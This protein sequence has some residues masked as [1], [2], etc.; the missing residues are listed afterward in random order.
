[1]RLP[2]FLEFLRPRFQ[3][4]DDQYGL[5]GHVLIESH[6]DGRFS[7][8]VYDSK[9]FIVDGGI[10]GLRNMILGSTT[11]G[12]DRTPGSSPTPLSVFRM[13][14]G[15]GGTPAGQLFSPR[16]PDAT[17][18]ARTGLFYEVLRQDISVFSAPSTV[19]ARFVSAF[20]S[21]DVDA[22]SFSLSNKVI[23][24]ASLIGGDGTLTIGGD[25]KQINKSPPD[26][27]DADEFLVSMRTFNSTP[28]NPAEDI[29]LTVTWTLSLIVSGQPF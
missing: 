14:I 23:N 16:Q 7:H 11:G 21:Q 18:P 12:G 1:M 24:E 2:P 8:V 28:F 27:A 4:Q 13:A 22:T 25:K 5:S 9:N 26:T 20:N 10:T 6:K 15:D 17:W 3:P 29:T 19:S